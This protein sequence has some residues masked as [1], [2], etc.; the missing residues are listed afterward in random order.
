MENTRINYEATR[1]LG[2]KIQNEAS[3]YE[4]IYS[5][6]IYG[7]FK[8]SLQNCFQGDDAD[9]AIAQLDGLR[10]DFEAMKNVVSEY[11]RRLIKAGDNYEEDMRASQQSA[12]R[13]TANRK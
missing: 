1:E 5:Q 9:T 6:E 3:K 13:L 12:S 10:D 11:G 4:S 2:R 8:S 7:S